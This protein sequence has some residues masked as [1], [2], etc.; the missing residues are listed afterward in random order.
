MEP[1]MAS[2]FTVDDLLAL[3]PPP[4]WRVDAGSPGGWDEVEQ[5][6]GT[7]LPDDYKLITNI[8]GWATSTTWLRVGRPDDWAI[9]SSIRIG[10]DRAAWTC[11]WSIPW[12][13]GSQDNCRIALAGGETL[14]ER[15]DPIFR[16]GWRAGSQLDGRGLSTR[17]SNRAATRQKCVSGDSVATCYKQ[18]KRGKRCSST[19]RALPPRRASTMTRASPTSTADTGGYCLSL[20]RFLNDE[21]VEVMVRDQ[22]NHK[23]PEIAVELSRD[24]LRVTLSPAAAAQLD[25]VT[26][27]TVP[28]ALSEDELRELDAALSAIFEGVSR[29]RYESR[30]Y[31]RS[32][33]V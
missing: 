24:E 14:R 3:A 15:T 13:S 26:E 4:E 31:D 7:A 8:Y 33:R 12:Y 27:Y 17:L 18:R 1:T 9:D 2:R 25:G 11:G 22:L 21:L 10:R 29:G 23:T 30:L 5:T 32:G 19:R 6:L 28:L 16:N 20:S